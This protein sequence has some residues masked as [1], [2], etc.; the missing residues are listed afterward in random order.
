[1]LGHWPANLHSE[2]LYAIQNQ[3]GQWDGGS[4]MMSSW[5]PLESVDFWLKDNQRNSRRLCY[6]EGNSRRSRHIWSDGET[7]IAVSCRMLRVRRFVTALP[8]WTQNCQEHM[9]ITWKHHEVFAKARSGKTTK[10]V[11]LHIHV[12]VEMWL[13]P[14]DLS[15]ALHRHAALSLH[16]IDQ[17]RNTELS[18]FIGQKRCHKMSTASQGQDTEDQLL[19]RSLWRLWGRHLKRVGMEKS[20]FWWL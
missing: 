8:V 4:W 14:F 5:N 17:G 15:Q 19:R 16:L 7:Q 13:V 10:N 3:S 2:I 18:C 20:G 9:R 6:S 1:M 11:E 12:M